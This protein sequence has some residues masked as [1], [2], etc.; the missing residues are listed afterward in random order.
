MGDDEFAGNSSGYNHGFVFADQAINQGGEY[1][2][3]QIRREGIIGMGFHK[4]GSTGIYSFDSLGT[5]TGNG[6][7]GLHWSTWFHP[8]PNGP[9]TYYGEASGQTSL[10][11]GWYNFDDSSTGADWLADENVLMKAGMDDN[12]HLYLSLIHISEPTRPY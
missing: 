1:Y 11:S 2:T 6:N 9:W 5:G 3:F 7:Y 10:K 4:S 8:T 12:G